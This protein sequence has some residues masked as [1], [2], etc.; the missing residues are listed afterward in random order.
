MTE[1]RRHGLEPVA[2]RGSTLVQRPGQHS[3]GDLVGLR[4]VI[5]PRVV[6]QVGELQ[7]LLLE[8]L[9]SDG[10]L[11]DILTVADR[12]RRLRRRGEEQDRGSS[13]LGSSGQNASAPR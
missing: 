5:D 1:R 7:A 2:E 13:A 4:R 6:L 10:A 8:V 11:E 12:K 3:L 9:V